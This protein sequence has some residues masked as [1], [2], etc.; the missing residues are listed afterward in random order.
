MGRDC[1]V[2]KRGACKLGSEDV[3]DYV[4][5]WRASHKE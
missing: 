1:R 3:K 4:D 2:D 5:E